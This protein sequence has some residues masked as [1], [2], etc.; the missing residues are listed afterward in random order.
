VGWEVLTA[1]V[2]VRRHRQNA[3]ELAARLA[4]QGR[5]V[6]KLDRLEKAKRLVWARWF[7]KCRLTA[8]TAFAGRFWGRAAGWAGACTW[9][10]AG[11]GGIGVFGCRGG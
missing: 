6:A 8:S 4:A 3:G 2:D 5:L 7:W 11:E 9:A 10:C 1:R